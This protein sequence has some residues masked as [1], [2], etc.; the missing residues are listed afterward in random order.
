MTVMGKNVLPEVQLGTLPFWRQF[1]RGF[2]QCAFQANEVTGLIFVIAVAT[3]SWRMAAFY[4][5]SVLIAT[6]VARL[7]KADR[8][9]LD[10]GL[11]GFNSGLMGLAMGNF[12]QPNTPLWVWVAVLAVVAALIAIAMGKW[13][14]IPF[15]AAP[16]ILTFWIMWFIAD[17]RPELVKLD[18]GPWPVEDVHWG[19]AVI[20]A[21]GAALFAPSVLTGLLFF[22]GLLVSNWRHAVIALVAA[23]IAVAISEHVGVAG[24][25]INT[26]FVGFNA[27][28]AALGTAAV[29]QGDLRMAVLAAMLATWFFS[30]INRNAPVPALASGFVLAVWFVMFLDWLHRRFGPEAQKDSALPAAVGSAPAAVADPSAPA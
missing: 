12:Y 28:L 3:Y 22:L 11:F 24:G 1:L 13:L 15:L 5:L 18:L 4:V 14:P 10:L 19:I 9:L 26:G 23:G 6:L 27:V 2:S 20:I 7:L 30:Y 8:T 17:A 21:L 25:A 16:F 29:L